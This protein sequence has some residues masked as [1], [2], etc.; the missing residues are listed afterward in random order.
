MI[1]RT[2]L[3]TAL[4]IL[5]L[6]GGASQAHAAELEITVTNATKGIFFTP[7]IAT[8][9]SNSFKL[10][11]SGDTATAELKAMAEGGDISG[12]AN[13]KASGFYR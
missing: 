11:K 13:R 12:L 4:S 8:A 10:F 6:F 5:G 1:K 2:T 9:H 7:I 3:T